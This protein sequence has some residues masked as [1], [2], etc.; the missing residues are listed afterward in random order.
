MCSS[1]IDKPDPSDQSD[2]V[3]EDSDDGGLRNSSSPS[4]GS[5]SSHGG[6]NGYRTEAC[7][8]TS[9][10]ELPSNGSRLVVD[11]S[12]PDAGRN[13]SMPFDEAFGDGELHV[14]INGSG[15]FH[16]TMA[17][18]VDDDLPGSIDG[19]QLAVDDAGFGG[20]GAGGRSVTNGDDE[21]E[22]SDETDE[23]VCSSR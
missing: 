9:H 4:C 14:S 20:I 6:S 7:E 8:S 18:L 1:A 11:T 5:S 23:V 15:R 19:F 2:D 10:A 21:P 3:G 22:L 12:G 13:S 17:S 16:G